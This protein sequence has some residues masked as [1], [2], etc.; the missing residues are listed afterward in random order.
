MMF[1]SFSLDLD[2]LWTYLK[3]QGNPEWHARPS[4]L[5][6]LVPRVL[7]LLDQ[8][9]AQITV[10]VVG[11]DAERSINGP[12][13]AAIAAA[14]HEIASHSY[15]HDP[16]LHLYSRAELNADLGRA[17]RAIAAAT[18]TRPTG[19]RGPGFS[20]SPAL[21]EVLAE[22]GYRYDASTLPTYLG[23][24]ARRYFLATSALS[25]AERR[26]R[27]GLFGG[28]RE[29]IRP[30]RPYWWRLP[31]GARLLEIPVTTM[32]GLKLPFHMSY[33]LYLRQRSPRL[34]R[35]Y[36]RAALAACRMGAVA[37]SFL[38]HPLDFL[39]GEEVPALGFFPAMNLT[40][41]AK[42]A[43]VREVMTILQEEFPM[44][45]MRLAADS[46]PACVLSTR[47]PD[48][49]PPMATVRAVPDAVDHLT[50]ARN[51]DV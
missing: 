44:G 42:M 48:R 20:W 8:L 39:G 41:G 3:T 32:P 24:L 14:G 51:S 16:W 6:W 37:P 28:F 33:L 38:L 4:Y 5:I 13:L 19:F 45:P 23:P 31:S 18:G 2:D 29:G 22:R 26:Q 1:G 25:P 27:A 12:T 43:A 10:F 15:A 17:E 21:L 36:L 34:M 46:A 30:A 40:R 49:L 9:G 50:A 47:S 35:A 11:E 7:E